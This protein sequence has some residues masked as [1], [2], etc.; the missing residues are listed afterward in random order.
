[1][2]DKRYCVGYKREGPRAHQADERHSVV[3]FM[4]NWMTVC[5]GEAAIFEGMAPPATITCQECKN[6][7]KGGFLMADFS[8]HGVSEGAS[9]PLHTRDFL[10]SRDEGSTG[11]TEEARRCLEIASEALDLFVRKNADY[12][13]NED[14]LGPASHYIDIHRKTKKLKR[15]LWYGHDAQF[16]DSEEM[17]MDLIGNCLRAIDSIRRAK[18]T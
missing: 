5:S 11:K 10:H 17:L 8:C 15:T 16:E 9:K 2:I 3:K 18:N 12:G 13:E 4:R 14:D 7:T 6:A 1:M